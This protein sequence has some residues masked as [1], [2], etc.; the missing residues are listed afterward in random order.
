MPARVED[1]AGLPRTW[2][3]TASLDLFRDEN[4]SYAQRLL[5]AGIP[6][7]LVVYEGACHGFQLIPGTKL[8]GRYQ[9]DHLQALARGLGVEI[10]E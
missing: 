3:M 4:I 6:T 7:E 5:A 8:G 10:Q 9:R 1:P 2:M